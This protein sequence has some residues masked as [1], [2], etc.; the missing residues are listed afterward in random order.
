VQSPGDL[1]EPR[2]LELLLRARERAR[3]HEASLERGGRPAGSSAR[4]R[5]ESQRRGIVTLLFCDI[6]GSTSLGEELDSESVR[7]LMFSYFHE[8]R[9]AIERHGGTVEK[10][11]G[12]AVMAVFGIPAVH[13]DD[14]LRAVR[15]AHEMQ[16]RLA[17]LNSKLEARFGSRI[18]L[19]IGVNTGEVTFGVG[20]A[21]GTMVTGDAVNVAA[22][23]EQAASPGE[24]LLGGQTLGL[25]RELVEV[26]A[27][28]SLVLR[29]K[30]QPV[31]AY[32]LLV[33]NEEEELTPRPRRTTL[34]GRRGELEFLG[35]AFSLVCSD[36]RCRLLIISG[37]PG[38]GKSRLV[39]EFLER[40][41]EALALRGRCLPRGEGV[42]YSPIA[43]MVRAVARIREEHSSAEALARLEGL[44]EIESDGTRVARRIAIAVGITAGAA[45]QEEIRWAFQRLFQALAARRPLVLEIS[46]LVYADPRLLELL[47][48][49]PTAC[50]APVL[51]LAAGRPEIVEAWGAS[52][53][54]LVRL[55]PLGVAEMESLLDALLGRSGEL[56]QLRTLIS[57]AAGGNPLFA[58][59]LVSMLIDEGVCRPVE[60]GVEL[61]GD[62]STIQAPPTLNSLLSARL[63]LLDPEQRALLE[64][65]SIE[66]Q[67]FHRGAAA[68]LL[69]V[70]SPLALVPTLEA[71]SARGLVQSAPALFAGE[72]AYRFRHGLVRDAAYSS[73]T[74]RGRATLHERFAF[75]LEGRAAEHLGEVEEVLAFHLEQAVCYR[76]ELGTL[77]ESDRELAAVACARLASCGRR[78]LAL[79]DA[80]LAQSLYERALALEPEGALELELRRLLAAA[81]GI[82]GRL[83]ELRRIP[84]F[85]RLPRLEFELL[86]RMVNVIDVPAGTVLIR[87]GKK[88]REFFAIAVGEVEISEGGTP[89]ATEEAGDFFGEIALLYD[90]PATATVTTKTPSRLYTLTAQAFRS[91]LA[92]RFV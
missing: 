23:L 31:P 41:P 71:L 54:N 82:E 76:V 69:G 92:R 49:L 4:T 89:I 28:G 38:V 3:F 17:G 33:V 88:G 75:W 70:E 40:V 18:A 67:L 26:E 58:E 2:Q 19:R 59:E 57:E 22:R 12:D 62:A 47:A 73:L 81:A 43:Q 87:E 66:G 36:R 60:Q 64:V 15:A 83:A 74:K 16:R 46:D 86:T 80:P 55:A 45:D 11:V 72:A 35:A 21:G 14:A 20:D 34:I 91:L 56:V 50:S 27:A 44:L 37:E 42:A 6:S 61:V 32:R 8:M 5:S 63:G 65:G 52:P 77:D 10:F 68:A 29:G 13:D 85:A 24:V 84:L 79:G 1:A 53:P 30:A 39:E 90:V 25:V 9:G 7:E 48:S 51:V 78:A